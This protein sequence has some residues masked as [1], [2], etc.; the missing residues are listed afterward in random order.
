MADEPQHNNDANGFE[1]W[2]GTRPRSLDR[3][4]LDDT[5][6]VA[7][8]VAEVLAAHPMAGGGRDERVAGVERRYAAHGHCV[9]LARRGAGRS[10]GATRRRPRPAPPGGR[11]RPTPLPA[12]ERR[13]R[14]TA[15]RHG[16]ERAEC[17]Q[18]QG[19][20]VAWPAGQDDGREM[21]RLRARRRR[22]SRARCVRLRSQ[23]VHGRRRTAR[24]PTSG[25]SGAWPASSP[26]RSSDRGRA[27][28]WR[29]P[30]SLGPVRDPWTARRRGRL[31]EGAGRLSGVQ[32]EPRAD[33][34]V[35]G[36][37]AS[38]DLVAHEPQFVD[39][40][41]RVPAMAAGRARGHRDVVAPFPRAQGGHRDRQQAARLLDGQGTQPAGP[42]DAWSSA[43]T[44]GHPVACRPTLAIAAMV[45]SRGLADKVDARGFA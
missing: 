31:D 2:R 1:S 18:P 17:F 40:Q 39:R 37:L 23:G 7:E 26:R 36:P 34:G 19:V 27:R 35:P 30:G 38:G 45:L 41:L 11:W 10:T 5:C 42:A 3:H 16:Q 28:R 22:S 15:G 32:Q 13:A 12:S 4:P 33:C 24:S 43:I 14:N 9:R 29:R 25:R 44:A 6:G 8:A 21:L 20:R